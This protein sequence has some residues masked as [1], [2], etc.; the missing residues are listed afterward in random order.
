M[1]LRGGAGFSCMAPVK[2]AL[3]SYGQSMFQAYASKG[4]H[5]AHVIIDGVI[6]SPNT[7]PWG[8]KVMLQDPK[9]LADAYYSLHEQKPS[10]WSYEIQLSPNRESVGMRM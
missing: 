8:E 9:D 3:R 2:T 5:V 4:I 6:E 1:A 7:K 10:V